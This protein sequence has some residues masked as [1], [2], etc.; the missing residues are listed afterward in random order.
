MPTQ[1]DPVAEAARQREEVERLAAIALAEE[2]RRREE[3]E[4]V[5]VHFVIGIHFFSGTSLIALL[6]NVGYL[7]A[8]FDGV[9]AALCVYLCI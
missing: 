5:C 3:E 6:V 9:S 4:E 2:T 7:H 8:T 1:S